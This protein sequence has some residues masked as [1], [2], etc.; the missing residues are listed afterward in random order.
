[1]LYKN[2]KV[3]VH[4]PDWDTD[5]FDIV[6]GVLQGDIFTLYLFII[7]LDYVLWTSNDKMKDDSFKLTKERRYP[8]QTITD[9][10]YADDIVLL[11]NTPV[12][13]ETLLRSLERAAAGIGLNVNADKTE[14]MCYNQRGEIFILNG[15]FLKLVNKFTYLGSSVS[16][17]ETN[18]NTR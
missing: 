1:M 7:C 16:L 6:A 11:A 14:C 17:T 5:Y 9:V 8:E 13:D 2:T 12:Q 15:S 18:I 3:K 4:T 10:D